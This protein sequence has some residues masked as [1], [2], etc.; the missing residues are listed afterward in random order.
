MGVS[1]DALAGH[2]SDVKLQTN[3][4]AIL[5]F[6]AMDIWMPMV[7][8][9]TASW[10]RDR[11]GLFFAK[12]RGQTVIHTGQQVDGDNDHDDNRDELGLQGCR[13]PLQGCNQLCAER[14][15]KGNDPCDYSCKC[16]DS[17]LPPIYGNRAGWCRVFVFA[18]FACSMALWFV[19]HCR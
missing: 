11:S 8:P 17:P 1:P 3:L 6:G 12:Q 16:K 5:G 7:R 10:L 15:D 14:L 2:Q 18:A 13:H 19:G 4:L 9:T